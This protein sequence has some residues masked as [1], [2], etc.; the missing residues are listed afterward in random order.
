MT[1]ERKHKKTC[2]RSNTAEKT[3]GDSLQGQK[4]DFQS[5]RPVHGLLLDFVGLVVRSFLHQLA[6]AREMTMYCYRKKTT[7]FATKLAD[8]LPLL[9]FPLPIRFLLPLPDALPLSQKLKLVCPHEILVTIRKV[10][11]LKQHCQDKLKNEQ[12]TPSCD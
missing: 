4:L 1:T 10:A 6:V 3:C 7:M 11:H 9:L 8:F 12:N 5:F 2:R